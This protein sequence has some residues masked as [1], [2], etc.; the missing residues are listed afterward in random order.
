MPLQNF[1][2]PNR[3]PGLPQRFWTRFG[4]VLLAVS[5]MAILGA[6]AGIAQT[7]TALDPTQQERQEPHA[8]ISDLA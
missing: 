6:G 7:P 4:T 2:N 8:I 5:T 1:L 3:Q